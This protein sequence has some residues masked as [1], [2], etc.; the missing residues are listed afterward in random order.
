MIVLLWLKMLHP[1]LPALVKQRYGSELRHKTLASIKPEISLA[2]TSLLDELHSNE[3][4]RTL[5]LEQTRKPF[6][7]AQQGRSR[8][9]KPTLQKKACPLCQQAGRP[10]F[11]H[12]L[13]VCPY[14]PEQDKKYMVRTRAVEV[15]DDSDVNPSDEEEPSVL[16][17]ETTSFADDQS[18]LLSRVTV[19]AYPHLEV[20][21]GGQ[22]IR[23]LL[24]SGAESSMIRADEAKRLG[25]RINP[26]TSQT[27]SQADG[28]QMT[29]IL[30]TSNPS[31]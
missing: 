19:R 21:H 15:A 22:P 27:P 12:Y 9:S 4:I 30:D 10:V 11:D 1:D 28:G 24:D 29:G 2:L 31:S 3:E 8:R 26:N 7:R 17:T 14:L 13:S 5:R 18:P 16:R 6:S 20:F 23:I 25:L